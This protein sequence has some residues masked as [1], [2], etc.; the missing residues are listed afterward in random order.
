MGLTARSL[1]LSAPASALLLGALSAPAAL[2]SGGGPYAPVLEAGVN[3]HSGDTEKSITGTMGYFLGFKAEERKGF[4]RPLVGFQLESAS[5][6]AHLGTDEPDF[7]LLGA[8]F[9][10]GAHLFP[11]REGRFQ[12]FVGGAGVLGWHYLK[13]ESPPT[14]VDPQTDSLSFGWEASAGVDLR[15]GQSRE[16]TGIR[17]RGS[18]WNVTSTLGGQSG[19]ELSG[20]RISLGLVY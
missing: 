9:L 18:L 16:G 15:L 6:T 17:L 2:A 3:L 10:A 4:F 19:F 14:D 12:P 5:G 8:S 20:W 11:F 1:R 7:S 13:M